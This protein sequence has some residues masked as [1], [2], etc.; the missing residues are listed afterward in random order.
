MGVTLCERENR[1]ITVEKVTSE[2]SVA[3]SNYVASGIQMR[4]HGDVTD[5]VSHVTSQSDAN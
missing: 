5:K 2:N 4:M 1:Q 3:L